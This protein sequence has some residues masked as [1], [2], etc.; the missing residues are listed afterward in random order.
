MMKLRRILKFIQTI[1]DPNVLFAIAQAASRRY[2]EVARSQMQSNRKL[3]VG[4][5]VSFR[6][7]N[8]KKIRGVIER[9]GQKN[10][11]IADEEG[12]VYRVPIQLIRREKEA[13]ITSAKRPVQPVEQVLPLVLTESRRLLQESGIELP[14]RYKPSVW[15]THFRAGRHIQYGERC[16][17]YQLTPQKA[18]DNVASNLRR[19]KLAKD[20]AA[21]LAML[22]I[23]E[24]SHAIAFQ[25]YGPTISPH[26]RQFYVVLSELVESEFEEMHQKFKNELAPTNG[27]NQA[28]A[29]SHENN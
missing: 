15:A 4:D 29:Q 21:R 9:R 2:Q 8:G 17:A 1:S 19:F 27:K 23:H 16:I 5:T 26:G 11:R 28:P 25:R 22:V 20:H 18:T 3:S 14:V 24:V 6:L 10:F 7:S 13:L 12:R